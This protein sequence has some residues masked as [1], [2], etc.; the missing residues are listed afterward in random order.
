LDKKDIVA[1]IAMSLAIIILC[2]QID[3]MQTYF[4]FLSVLGLIKQK[5]KDI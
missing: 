4:L 5:K 2:S 3:H 1:Y